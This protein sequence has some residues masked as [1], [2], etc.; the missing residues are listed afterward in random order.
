LELST[1]CP[2]QKFS[3]NRSGVGQK[4]LSKK[5]PH[6]QWITTSWHEYEQHWLKLPW[7]MELKKD[8]NG[9]GRRYCFFWR[10]VFGI[11]DPL[12]ESL[13]V[14]YRSDKSM[15]D[16][17]SSHEVTLFSLHLRFGSTNRKDRNAQHKSL[18]F[19]R[20]CLDLLLSLRILT[21]AVILLWIDL[22][23]E[24]MLKLNNLISTPQCRSSHVSLSLIVGQE[25]PSR[26]KRCSTQ[27]YHQPNLQ[28]EHGIAHTTPSY[29]W[30]CPS[31]FRILLICREKVTYFTTKWQI[32]RRIHLQCNESSISV[33]VSRHERSFRSGLPWR[34]RCCACSGCDCTSDNGQI[35]SRQQQFT[36]IS[37]ESPT[38]R[39]S[40]LSTTEFLIPLTNN[41]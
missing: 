15:D 14:V 18:T 28:T 12:D 41:Q 11:A 34:T 24:Q 10:R 35:D 30:E 17:V 16:A 7:K 21:P 39:R 19:L 22:T 36:E 37:S 9:I 8:W 32:T 38:N 23:D 13:T 40:F 27:V 26:P 2:R 5:R 3:Q 31:F 25:H 20:D 29:P 4:N 33:R 1:V 6:N